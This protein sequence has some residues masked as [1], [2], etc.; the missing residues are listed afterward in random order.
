[1]TATA[2]ALVG[3]AIAAT[4]PDPVLGVTLSFATHPILDMIPHWDF[5]RGW[6][7]KSKKKFFAE[8]S[9]DFSL[10]LVLTFFIFGQNINP[11]YLL[12]CIFAAELLDFIEAPYWF[13]GWKFPPFSTSYNFMSKIQ[14]RAKFW[15]GI[16]TQFATVIGTFLALQWLHGIFLG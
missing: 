9:F 6:Q 12:A 8:A 4:I 10:G 14:G 11:I 5:G 15:P 3:G 1:M 7:K 13:L 16:A 2:H